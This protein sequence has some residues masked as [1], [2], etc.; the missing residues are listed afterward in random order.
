MLSS[1]L[2]SA[3]ELVDLGLEPFEF[4]PFSLGWVSSQLFCGPPLGLE[5]LRLT[6]F[7]GA[8]YC[9][10]WLASECARCIVVFGAPTL[11]RLSWR[12][13]RQRAST[14]RSGKCAR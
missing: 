8:P 10:C 11:K 2:L 1:A 3:L 12:E 6:S 7:Q 13:K 5:P 14:G 9:M 4:Q